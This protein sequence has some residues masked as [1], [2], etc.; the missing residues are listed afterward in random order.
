MVINAGSKPAFFNAFWTSFP[1]FGTTLVS[2][3]IAQR[4]AMLNLAH[5][6]PNLLSSPE[7]ILIS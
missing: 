1:N 4:L 5:S 7:P 6:R 2:E 3:I